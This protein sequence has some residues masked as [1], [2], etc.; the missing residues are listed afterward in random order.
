[1]KRDTEESRKQQTRTRRTRRR[2]STH[3]TS[4]LLK[5]SFLPYQPPSPFP[6]PTVHLAGRDTQELRP[7]QHCKRRK[8][9]FC[10]SQLLPCPHKE[11]LINTTWTGSPTMPPPSMKPSTL[12]PQVTT[13]LKGKRALVQSEQEKFLFFCTYFL[14]KSTAAG[15]FSLWNWSQFFFTWLLLLVIRNI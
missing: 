1:M 13:R 15:N 3:C 8:F 6:L 2:T 4:L 9:V 5:P 7:K 14:N 10:F 12:L 11:I